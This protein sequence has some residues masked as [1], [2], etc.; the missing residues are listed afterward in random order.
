MSEDDRKQWLEVMEGKEPVR[1]LYLEILSFLFYFP[2][3][4]SYMLLYK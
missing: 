2:L 1:H 4:L 3:L